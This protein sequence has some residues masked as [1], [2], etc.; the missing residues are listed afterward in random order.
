L[1]AIFQAVLSGAT[2]IGLKPV[3][4]TTPASIEVYVD[5]T[6]LSLGTYTGIITVSV[7]GNTPIQ[8][9]VNLTILGQPSITTVTDAASGLTI[10]TSK[11][12]GAGSGT[13]ATSVAGLAPGSIFTIWGKGL[14]PNNGESLQLSNADTV[15]TT[16]NNTSVTVDGVPAPLLF[17][18][19]DQIN[20]IMPFEVAG[21][22]SVPLTVQ[23]YTAQSSPVQLAVA[24]AEPALF[25][26][27]MSG[28]GQAAVLNQDNGVNSTLNPAERGSIVTLWGQG[29]GQTN[30][31][32][33]DGKLAGAGGNPLPKPILPVSVTIDGQDAQVLY[34]GAAPEMVSGLLQIN[35]KV[36]TNTKTGAVPVVVNVG[37]YSSQPGV[38][39]AVK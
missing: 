18:Q 24:V 28:R 12:A 5:P 9:P 38:T 29:A 26:V 2:W 30:P 21:K 1:P 39:L 22:T 27:D 19:N 3:L 14:G 6:G 36:P 8:V 15:S 33:V 16:L 20:A 10:T 25:T 35:V 13:T 31:P 17:V 37:P 23:R 32:G 7:N 11:P 34:A 4:A